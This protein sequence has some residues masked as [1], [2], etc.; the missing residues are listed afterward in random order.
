MRSFASLRRNFRPTDIDPRELAFFRTGP[1]QEPPH[2]DDCPAVVQFHVQ[3]VPG[4]AKR[5]TRFR[6]RPFPFFPERVQIDIGQ[7]VPVI[8]KDG[9]I[10]FDEVLDVLQAPAGFEQDGLMPE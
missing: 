10:A 3:Q 1:A 8:D 5:E 7:D 2:V 9:V 4:R 6:R